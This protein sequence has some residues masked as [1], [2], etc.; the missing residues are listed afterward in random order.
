MRFKLAYFTTGKSKYI[1]GVRNC[2]VN[3]VDV[4]FNFML[5]QHD[6]PPA[7]KRRFHVQP[8]KKMNCTASMKVT[9]MKVY[10]EYKLGENVDKNLHDKKAEVSIT[11]GNKSKFKKKSLG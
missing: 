1:Q 8:S 6:H 4:L 3:D 11:L 10:P 7:K 2:S 5:L 9:K